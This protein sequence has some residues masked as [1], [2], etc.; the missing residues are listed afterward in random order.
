METILSDY[1][2][3]FRNLYFETKHE[4]NVFFSQVCV[5]VLNVKIEQIKIWASIINKKSLAVCKYCLELKNYLKK[6]N[7]GFAFLVSEGFFFSFC[8]SWRISKYVA[9]PWIHTHYMN[10][11]PRERTERLAKLQDLSFPSSCFCLHLLPP[12]PLMFTNFIT[13]WSFIGQT[14]SLTSTQFS[15]QPRDRSKETNVSNLFHIMRSDV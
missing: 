3:I 5:L 10:T 4:K 9:G 7:S 15:F 2:V 6:L 1:S 11:N 14:K 13:A 8:V 12:C